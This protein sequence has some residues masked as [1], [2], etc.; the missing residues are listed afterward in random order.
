MFSW[1]WYREIQCASNYARPKIF[2]TRIGSDLVSR[3]IFIFLK[4]LGIS[5]LS[6]IKTS[7][8]VQVCLLTQYT[9]NNDVEQSDIPSGLLLMQL[10]FLP[11]RAFNTS[12]T[13]PSTTNLSRILVIVTLA[14]GGVPNSTLQRRWTSAILSTFQHHFSNTYVHRMI[15]SL[16]WLFKRIKNDERVAM[17][18]QC[19][20][21]QTQQKLYF[22]L[23]SLLRNNASKSV[24]INLRQSIQSHCNE[25]SSP[26][27]HASFFLC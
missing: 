10:L 25:N 14:G 8:P 5:I 17:L 22:C 12:C 9:P 27:E 21:D 1:D 24:Y 4:K 15:I 16:P 18:F 23:I 6:F 3:R 13:V 7:N 2:H 26:V 19:L 20:L 11:H